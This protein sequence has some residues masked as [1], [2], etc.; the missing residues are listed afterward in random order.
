MMYDCL[1][2]PEWFHRFM[3]RLSEAHL[4][5]FQGLEAEGH[6]TRNDQGY[7][8]RPCLACGELPKPGFDPDRVRFT[9]IWCEADAQ[10]FALVSSEMWEEFLLEYQLPIMKMHGLVFYGCCESLVGKLEI[11]RKKVPNLRRI[12]VSPWSDLEYSS[13]CCKKEVVMQ[14]RPMPSEIL[15]GFDEGDMRKDLEKKMEMAG[16][17]IY[18][19]CLQDIET[20]NGHPE[21]LKAWTRIA[22]EVGAERY[23]R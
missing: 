16:D 22:K 21:I 19:F 20:V 8:N 23:N 1:D 14:I 5:H 3:K 12:T 6:V 4:R 2:R 9:D 18:E 13:R 15:M 10:E 11:L 17:T 7:C